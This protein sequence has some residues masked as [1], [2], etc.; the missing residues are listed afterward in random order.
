MKQF[1]NVQLIS[2]QKLNVLT[3][4]ELIMDKR[5]N[6]F[7]ER[8]YLHFYNKGKQD[9]L[10]AISMVLAKVK[11]LQVDDKFELVEHLINEILEGETV[12]KS[13]V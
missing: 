7:L 5:L 3:N 10:K 1:L 4:K 12:S 6:E 8:E 9:V 2:T 11:E 13:E